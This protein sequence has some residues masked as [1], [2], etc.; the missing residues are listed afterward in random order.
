MTSGSE[1]RSTAEAALRALAARQHGV[2]SAVQA[3]AL[4]IAA[5][6]LTRRLRSGAID[7]LLPGVYRIVGVPPTVRQTIV[8]GSLWGGP[9]AVLSHLTA[10]A[11]WS[12]D[13]VAPGD[14]ELWVPSKRIAPPGIVVHRGEIEAIDVRMRDAMQLTSPARTLL[15]VAIRLD[16][17]DFEAAAESAFRRGI[18]NPASVRRRLDAIGRQ[19]SCRLLAA[20]GVPRTSW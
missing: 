5:P 9:G 6:A 11:L 17:E 2:F 10:A 15:D 1:K 16:D 7:R 18:T 12:L 3:A 14:V 13:G 4:G 20:A 8:A 19:R